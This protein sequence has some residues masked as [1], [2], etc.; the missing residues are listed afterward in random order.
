[1]RIVRFFH[2]SVALLLYTITSAAAAAAQRTTATTTTT[3]PTLALASLTVDDLIKVVRQLNKDKADLKA[4]LG[5]LRSRVVLAE[6][7]ERAER[8]E[9]GR[10]RGAQDHAANLKRDS[11]ATLKRDNAATTK[12]NAACSAAAAAKDAAHVR[13]VDAVRRAG[14]EDLR[15]E[16]ARV[17]AVEATLVANK[18]AASGLRCRGL[19][20]EQRRERAAERS[21]ERAELSASLREL[22]VLR[23]LEHK[24]CAARGESFGVDLEA[25]EVE[26]AAK[27]RAVRR[28]RWEE[29]GKQLH[30]LGEAL[31]ATLGA[32]PQQQ[33]MEAQTAAVMNDLNALL[34]LWGR[35]GGGSGDGNEG[36]NG[37]RGRGA[38]LGAAD[39]TA[40]VR[41]VAMTP[42]LLLSLV[43][44]RTF[45]AAVRAGY[46]GGEAPPR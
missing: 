29:R 4:D 3:H 2:C 34:G 35:G 23:A 14:K 22:R 1:M 5:A 41:G 7:N 27:D 10:A 6:A 8:G 39:W 44:W 42:W 18:A 19:E 9:A 28:R 31:R 20:K 21:Q 11:A 12:L 15:R 32:C 43:K 26:W 45:V 13:A 37:G 16:V 38:A 33:D 25:R 36:L 24:S 30:A 17:R 40:W 46:G